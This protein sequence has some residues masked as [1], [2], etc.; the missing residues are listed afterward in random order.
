MIRILSAIILIPLAILMV[1]YAAPP[2]FLIA[3]GL[4]GT[5]CLQ[6]Y[7]G[8]IRALGIAVQPVFGFAAFWILLIALYQARFP[9]AILFA[10]VMLAAFL[11]AMWRHRQAV[12]S[13]ALAMMAEL[14]GIFYFTL[15]LFPALPIRYDFGN[16]IGLGW[17]I[18]LL[19]VIWAGDTVA[20]VIG[21]LLGKH[22]FAPVL[23]PKKT[24][25]GAL[26][27][28]LAGIGIA[29]VVQQLLF[30][31]LLFLHTA[32]ASLVLGIFGQAG[33][34]AESMLK[35]AAAIKDSSHRIPG[36]GGVLDRMDSL[37]F[38]LPVLYFYLLLI[39]Q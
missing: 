5:F 34:L 4:I 20:L 22:P 31:D 19:A 25:E 24:W 27:G 3:I 8:L 37:L 13:R 18:I 35:R 14:L 12:R 29:M 2:Y 33:D 16:R 21:K 15:C 10:I 38:G 36:H 17:F 1:I 23:S 11:S 9:A 6:E 26:A 28:L 30:P 32:I 7:F 39:Y